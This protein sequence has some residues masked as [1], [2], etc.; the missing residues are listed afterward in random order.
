MSYLLLVTEITP[1]RP[2]A[3]SSSLLSS[4]VGSFDLR[5]DCFL[6][7]RRSRAQKRPR[8]ADISFTLARSQSSHS[9]RPSSICPDPDGLRTKRKRKT[10]PQTIRFSLSERASV[11]ER[12]FLLHRPTDRLLSEE[13]TVGEREAAAA[14]ATA[15]G[16]GAASSSGRQRLADYPI[17]SSFH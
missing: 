6:L 13:K 15:P 4:S 1:P 17:D 9:T 3:T 16:K 2:R 7:G 8:G 10:D 14:D 11:R 5:H 12:P